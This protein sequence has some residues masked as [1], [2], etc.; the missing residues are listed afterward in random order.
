LA[1]FQECWGDLAKG[2]HLSQVPGDGPDALV[3]RFNARAMRKQD[4]GKRR[5]EPIAVTRHS[6]PPP[7]SV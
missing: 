6:R 2:A 5:N 7:L 4:D 1:E 3:R